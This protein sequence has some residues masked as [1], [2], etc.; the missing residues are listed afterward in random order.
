MLKNNN[1][2]GPDDETIQYV[3]VRINKKVHSDAK[4]KAKSLNLSANAYYAGLVHRD[5]YANSP[6]SMV[7]LIANF[8]EEMNQVKT[9]V[10]QLQAGQNKVKETM[11]S[12]KKVLKIRS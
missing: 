6:D 4:E 10:A 12:I 3:Q 7:E 1:G 11:Q 8:S 2:S 9:S 5:L